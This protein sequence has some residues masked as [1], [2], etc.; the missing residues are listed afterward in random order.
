MANLTEVENKV[1][2]DIFNNGGWVLDYNNITFSSFFKKYNINIDDNIYFKYGTSKWKRLKCFFEI[3]DDFKAGKILEQLVLVAEYQKK[4]ET[5]IQKQILEKAIKRLTKN[6]DRFED[7][8]FPNLNLNFIKDD[9]LKKNLLERFKEAN[10]CYS[11]KSYLATIFLLGS[12]LEGILLDLIANNIIIFN[13]ANSSPKINRKVKTINQWTLEEMINT[14][15]ELDFIKLDVSS[16][17]KTLKAFRNYIHPRQQLMH[18]FSPNEHTVKI[19]IHVVKAAVYEIN[20]KL[21]NN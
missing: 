14:A 4:I 12:I 16:H 11:N 20:L 3:T 17:C 7:I 8:N 2:N 13:Q 1:I 9:G 6:E 18:G 10:I 21:N 15:L 5:I 19:S